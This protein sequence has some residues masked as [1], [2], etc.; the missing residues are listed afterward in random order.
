M[1]G[2]QV[3]RAEDFCSDPDD[4]YQNGLRLLAKNSHIEVMQQLIKKGAAVWLTPLERE[5]D[6]EFFFV[7]SGRLS[8]EV[9]GRAIELKSGDSF[10][11]RGIEKELHFSALEETLLVYCST[12]PVFDAEDTFQTYLRDMIQKIDDKDHYTFQHSQNVMRYSLKLYS[13]LKDRCENISLNNIIMASLFH[14]I[15]K[16]KI[17]DEILKKSAHLSSEEFDVIK[18]HPTYGAEILNPYYEQ[19][20]RDIVL[21]HHERLDGSGYPLGIK[22]DDISFAA[23]IVAV[24]DAFDAMTTNRKYNVPKS[25]SVAAAELV[26]LPEK[27]DID[28]SLKLQELISIGEIEVKST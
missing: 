21:Y 18:K 5:D 15:G 8:V 19:S 9:D 23:R 6:T 16:I 4:K 27:F 12:C 11:S 3:N 2:F 26:S 1:K 7:H 14:D 13:A 10:S 17:P 28:V 25:A 22:K 20:I 24:S